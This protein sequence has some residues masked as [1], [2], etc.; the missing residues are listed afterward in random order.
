M[1]VKAAHNWKTNA[2]L[3]ADVA[4]LGYLQKEDRI[5]DPT[6]GRGLWWTQ[7]QPAHLH[8]H[9]LLLDGV[10]F[11][12]LPY[13]DGYFDSIAF[14]PPYVSVGGRKT[15]TIPDFHNRYGMTDAPSSPASLQILINEGLTE[16][17]RLLRKRG[18]L[19]CKVQD[20]ISSGK[21]WDGTHWTTDHAYH[22]GF[23]KVD[24]L[25]H[26]GSTR[27]QPSGRRQVHARRNLST[28]FV[29][30]KEH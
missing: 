3:I 9:D 10:D 18:I 7:W 11:R 21:F 20:Y 23:E 13:E 4:Q 1:I 30:R 15:T 12:N 28:L 6:F 14:D 29:F 2:D 27:A 25:E 26:M 22:L 5:L 8:K 17:Y 16:M 24:R 19:L